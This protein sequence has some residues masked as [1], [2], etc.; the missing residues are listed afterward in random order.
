M[1]NCI[2]LSPGN[3][4]PTYGADQMYVDTPIRFATATFELQDTD[5][6]AAVADLIYGRQ[7]RINR[8]YIS[9]RFFY[10]INEIDGGIGDSSITAIAED[11]KGN[12]EETFYIDLTDE[13]QELLLKH[14]DRAC[15]NETGNGVRYY[16]GEAVKKMAENND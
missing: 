8:R 4:L 13:E 12:T 14:L 2:R 7:E 5:I 3:E 9:Y 6:L 10:G 11:T 15:M 16:L 1:Q